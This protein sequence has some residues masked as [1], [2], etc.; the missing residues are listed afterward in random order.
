LRSSLR[1]NPPWS[2]PIDTR[3][4]VPWWLSAD[5]SGVEAPISGLTVQS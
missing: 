2:V 1:S 4:C 5:R 3:T